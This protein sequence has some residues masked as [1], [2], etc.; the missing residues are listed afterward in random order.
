MSIITHTDRTARVH[1]VF[2]DERTA[3]AER[4]TIWLVNGSRDVLAQPWE[5]P[6]AVW[7]RVLDTVA[8]M[9]VAITLSSGHLY[10]ATVFADVQP[11]EQHMQTIIKDRVSAKLY[12]MAD[13][14]NNKNANSRVKA[15]AALAELHGLYQ[16]GSFTLPTLEQ[17]NAAI[18]S[19]H[20]S[21]TNQG[22]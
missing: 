17:I 1:V 16:P 2:D 20:E 18:A 4:Y 8:A 12:E 15:L 6:A 9:R 13:P 3:P 21:T 22:A 11:T 14:A 19:H 10:F 5:S 7:K